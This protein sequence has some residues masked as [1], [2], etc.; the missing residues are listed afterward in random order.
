M[1]A[2]GFVSMAGCPQSFSRIYLA[3]RK[4]VTGSALM[5]NFVAEF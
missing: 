1:P 4:N 3:C 2:L 5:M